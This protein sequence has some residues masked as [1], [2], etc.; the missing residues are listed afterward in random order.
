MAKAWRF[1]T[2][3]AATPTWAGGVVYEQETTDVPIEA[4]NRERIQTR[5]DQGITVL[6]GDLAA[7]PGMTSVPEDVKTI[8]THLIRGE[9]ALARL[10]SGRFESDVPS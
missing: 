5:I 7:L 2:D 8:L 3:D 10:A 4:V 9:I 6:E 1:V